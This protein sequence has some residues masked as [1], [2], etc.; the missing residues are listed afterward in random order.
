MRPEGIEPSTYLCCTPDAAHEISR[1]SLCNAIDFSALDRNAA[2]VIR[3]KGATK[4]QHDPRS[5]VSE[6]GIEISVRTG[7][8]TPL[9]GRLRVSTHG[10]T[11]SVGDFV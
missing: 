7:D 6:R 5:S 10:V 4:V 11:T 8:G 9:I 3:F 2:R 1:F